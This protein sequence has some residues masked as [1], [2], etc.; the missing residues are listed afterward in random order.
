MIGETALRANPNK[1][2]QGE[3]ILFKLSIQPFLRT[4]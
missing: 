1:V 2:A 4:W 3:G